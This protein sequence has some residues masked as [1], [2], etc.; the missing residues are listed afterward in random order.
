MVHRIVAKRYAQALFNA[1]QDAKVLDKMETDLPLVTATLDA[2]PELKMVLNHPVISAADK[3][4]VIGKLFTGKVSDML[5]NFMMLIVEK[6]RE[7]L[8]DG[9]RE[10][11]GE[12]LME[13][14]GQVRAEVFTA[15]ELPESMKATLTQKLSAFTGKTVELSEVVDPALIG[16][17]RVRM[18]DRVLDGSVHSGLARMKETLLAVK[19]R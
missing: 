9:I 2:N 17:V 11:F 7:G 19:V 14:R 16:G 18:G 10:I 5:V 8:L 13:Y 15:F 4:I 6:N 1:A 12:L 3:K